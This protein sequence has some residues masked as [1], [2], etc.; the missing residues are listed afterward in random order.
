MVSTLEIFGLSVGLFYAVVTPFA[1]YFVFRR[2]L[3]LRLR[4][5]ALG[6]VGYF[7]ASRLHRA[8]VG[9]AVGALFDFLMRAHFD[10][11]P[12]VYLFLYN[13]LRRS[14][15]ETESALI[16]ALLLFVFASKR[17]GLAPGAAYAIGSGGGYCFARVV[18]DCVYLQWALSAN[19]SGRFQWWADSPEIFARIF[20][21]GIPH[22]AGTIAHFLVTVG[23]SLLIWKGVRERRWPPVRAAILVAVVLEALLVFAASLPSLSTPNSF[24]SPFSPE[25]CDSILGLFIVAL[26]YWRAQILDGARKLSTIRPGAQ[27]EATSLFSVWRAQG[28]RNSDE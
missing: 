28:R 19:G 3:A 9:P 11:G 18:A 26:I 17:S 1:A 5:V 24:D 7:I 22:G 12:G 4:H 16:C 20:S 21:Q 13:W 25:I 15:A 23:L 8:I 6:I 2:P 10:P 14:V 27:A